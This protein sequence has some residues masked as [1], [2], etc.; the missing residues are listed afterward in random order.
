M[1][2][3]HLLATLFVAAAL[4]GCAAPVDR[5]NIDSFKRPCRYGPPDASLR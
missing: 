5:Q 3:I 2:Q 1:R 4:A